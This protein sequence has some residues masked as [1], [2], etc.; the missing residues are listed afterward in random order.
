MWVYR[1]LT[2]CLL[3]SL[4]LSDAK[5]QHAKSPSP[6]AIDKLIAGSTV[7]ARASC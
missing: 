3:A 7:R 1:Y 2:A 5:R 6:S 4:A